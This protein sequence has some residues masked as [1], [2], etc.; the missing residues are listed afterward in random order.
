VVYR[1]DDGDRLIEIAQN[2]FVAANLTGI[3]G[4]FTALNEVTSGVSVTP[5][6]LLAPQLATSVPALTA[7]AGDFTID[8]VSISFDP[9][10]DTLESLRDSINRSVTT[11]KASIDSGGNLV[12]Q[13]LTSGDVRMAN[14]TSNVLEVL[15]MFHRVEGGAIGAGITPA[16]TL[17][18]LGI[19][20]DAIS[21]ATG[22][23]LYRIDLSGAVTVQDAIDAVAASGAPVEAFV[24]SAG[25]GLVF[26]ATESVDSLEVSS[27]RRIYGSSALGPGALDYATTLA[28]LGITAGVLDITND[29]SMTSLD[30][31]A[32]ITVGDVLDAINNQVNGVSAA[33]NSD[34][35]S[36]D[37]ESSFF[38]SSLSAA[39]AGGADIATV[40]GFAQTRSGDNAADFDA[41]SPGEVD[42]VESENIFRTLLELKAELENDDPDPDNVEEIL[43]A[44]DR[45]LSLV[46]TNRSTVGA[47]IN[48]LRMTADRLESFELYL[49]QL[50]SENEDADLAE[51]ATA[52][53]THTNILEAALNA[54]ARIIQP[55]L[56]N[57][58]V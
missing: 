6:A 22:E 42:E 32:A 51:T 53:A 31:S 36:I 54:G 34:G 12:V 24:N 4:F 30:L 50:L 13:S 48:R 43:S 28:S 18:A 21:I 49:T 56:L 38:S 11:A 39:D 5:D 14:G 1:G 57:F 9:A 23:D 8:G 10:T 47:R 40:L 15:D 33:I 29:G 3:D 19:T 45:D 17:A 41:E 16:T 25:T 27:L 37:L 35:S 58:L 26:S 20:G 55:S 44:F 7:V 52:I 46:L 2:E